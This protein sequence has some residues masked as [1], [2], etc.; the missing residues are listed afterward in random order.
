[1]KFQYY[2]S[3]LLTVIALVLSSSSFAIGPSFPC[4]K[5]VTSNE[6]LICK[7]SRLSELDYDIGHFYSQRIKSLNGNQAA[8]LRK[9]QRSWLKTRDRSCSDINCLEK[10]YEKRIAELE[11]NDEKYKRQYQKSSK[12]FSVNWPEENKFP[13]E[14]GQWQKYIYDKEFIRCG[15]DDKLA[16]AY[17]DRVKSFNFDYKTKCLR[18]PN[19]DFGWYEVEWDAQPLRIIKLGKPNDFVV[20][21]TVPGAGAS[22][23]DVWEKTLVYKK[24]ANHEG[25]NC[26][27]VNWLAN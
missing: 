15:D 8:Q 4:E 20:L 12:N 1:M 18:P 22:Y 9:A 23:V 5:T 21:L 7:S 25:G 24:S 14:V 10:M 2:F 16:S 19:V 11:K 13:W 26:C 6:Q 17:F 3:V 27:Y